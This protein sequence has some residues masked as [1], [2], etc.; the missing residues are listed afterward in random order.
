M[1]QRERERER[2]RKNKS[3]GLIV[4]PKFV[5]TSQDLLRFFHIILMCTKH[6]F[7]QQNVGKQPV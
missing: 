6:I 2:E 4:K 3:N 5:Y 1:Y 7:N